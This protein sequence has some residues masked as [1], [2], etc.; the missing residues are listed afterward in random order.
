[1]PRLSVQ[2]HLLISP[3]AVLCQARIHSFIHSCQKYLMSIPV[4]QTLCLT[5]GILWPDKTDTVP[6]LLRTHNHG[7]TD[8]FCLSHLTCIVHLL[9]LSLD[10][11]TFWWL[12]LPACPALTDHHGSDRSL[13][14]LK[15]SVA[16]LALGRKGKGPQL[17]AKWVTP[18]LQ[19]PL[20]TP[21]L[22]DLHLSVVKG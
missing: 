7:V 14:S 13:P 16:T 9:R 5:L 10:P 4:S 11:C 1:M 17:Q 18:S 20:L 19:P 6:C 15:P 21:H 8:S 22:S 12:S 2:A 3:S